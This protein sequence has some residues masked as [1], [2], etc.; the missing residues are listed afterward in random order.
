MNL[1]PFTNSF[2]KLKRVVRLDYLYNKFRRQWF[3][4]H[5]RDRL[6]FLLFFS[7]SKMNYSSIIFYVFEF[8]KIKQLPYL[9]KKNHKKSYCQNAFLLCHILNVGEKKTYSKGEQKSFVE[10]VPLTSFTKWAFYFFKH[11]STFL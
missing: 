1:F 9:K 2:Q 6:V 5:H 3:P 7:L 10:R 11:T 4:A 8:N